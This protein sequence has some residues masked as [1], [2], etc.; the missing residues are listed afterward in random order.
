MPCNNA[1]RVPVGNPGTPSLQQNWPCRPLNNATA[2][3]SAL[4]TAEVLR[5]S[6]KKQV[7]QSGREEEPACRSKSKSAIETPTSL[8]GF[9][10]PT[11]GCF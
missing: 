3:P 11:S 8:A 9:E 10:L 2:S 1:I 7:V 6:Q 5:N 4:Q